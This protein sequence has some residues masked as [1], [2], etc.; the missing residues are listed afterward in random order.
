MVQSSVKSVIFLLDEQTYETESNVYAH[1]ILSKDV[2]CPLEIIFK[3][4]SITDFIT[5]FK[6]VGCIVMW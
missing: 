6:Y 1:M 3:F 5:G 4:M 2:E